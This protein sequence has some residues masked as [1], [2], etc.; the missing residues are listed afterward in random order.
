MVFVQASN[1]FSTSM[2]K[3]KSTTNNLSVYK[4]ESTRKVV[5]EAEMQGNTTSCPSNQKHGD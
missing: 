1:I 2:T 3:E 4:S 5:Q